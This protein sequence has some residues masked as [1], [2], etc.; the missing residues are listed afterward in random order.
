MLHGLL[1][2]Y[3]FSSGREILPLRVEGE[4][5]VSSP[6]RPVI[7]SSQTNSVRIFNRSTCCPSTKVFVSKVTSSLQ[8]SGKEF[9]VFH[10]SYVYCVPR[11]PVSYTLQKL[12]LCTFYLMHI[13]HRKILNTLISIYSHVFKT[14]SVV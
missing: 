14:A 5:S 4:V 3:I 9:R 1:G 13:I 12:H 2:K 6:K 7:G 10:H 8:D 11:S